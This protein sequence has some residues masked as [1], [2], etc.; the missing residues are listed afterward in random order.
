MCYLVAGVPE[1][2]YTSRDECY[3]CHTEN[4]KVHHATEDAINN[5]C[6]EV[7]HY[8]MSLPDGWRECT[9]CHVDFNHHEGAEGKCVDCHDDRQQKRR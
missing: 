5:R 8:D 6:T 2:G 1:I 7:C 9:Y 3:V 4:V